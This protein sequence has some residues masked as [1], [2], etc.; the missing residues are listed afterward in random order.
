MAWFRAMRHRHA[1]PGH[2]PGLTPDLSGRDVA[3]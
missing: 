2:G 3:R 1:P